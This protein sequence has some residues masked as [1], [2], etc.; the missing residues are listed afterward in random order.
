MPIIRDFQQ[1]DAPAV[2][3]LAL[4][5]FEQFKNAYDDWPAFQAKIANMSSL[6]D[7]G[8]I[9]VVEVEGQIVGA[10]AYIGPGAPKAKFF[11][12]EWPI[13]RMLVVSPASRGLGIGRALAE[14]C[15]RRT[16]RDG[17][18]VFALHTSE[19]MRV[20]LPMYQR[21]GFKWVSDTPAIH[22]VEY[23]VYLKELDGQPCTQEDGLRPPLALYLGRL[24]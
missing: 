21:M 23:G 13:M 8:E 2:N 19:L 16:K 14:E 22:G 20:A 5:A 4:R 24:I 15:L 12:P 18:S 1:S 10:V 3:A 9:V 17:A 11:Q 6:A 7:V